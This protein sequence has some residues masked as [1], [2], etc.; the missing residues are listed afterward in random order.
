M[1]LDPT[2]FETVVPS[3]YIT[4]TFPNPLSNHCHL[5]VAVLDSP[6]SS[7]ARIASMWVPP[8]RES[9]WIFS[10]FSGH[11]QLLLSS[12]TPHHLSR[13]ILIGNPPVYSHP[14]S[15]SS[16]PYPSPN[17]SKEIE[18][19]LRPLLLG[20]TPK[21]AF[22]QKGICNSEFLQI[23][24]LIYEDEVVGCV[25]LEICE[26]PCAG[27]MLIENVAVET[28]TTKEFR[29]RLRFK[30]MPN[31]VQTQMRILPKNELDSGE[32]NNLE[33]E[34][35][36]N[37]LVH[38]YLSPMVGGLSVTE[39]HLERRIK[40]GFRPKALCLGIGGGA[41]L[42][43]LSSQLNFDVTGVEKD[44]VVLQIAKKYFGLESNE[45]IHL[46][47]GDGIEL[48][49]KLAKNITADCKF[50]VIMVDLDSSDVTLGVCAPPLEFVKKSVLQAAREVL[51]EHGVL[52]INVIPSSELFY[53]SLISEFE[54]VFEE[55][56]E[57]DVGNGENFVLIATV[58]K[59][60]NA[61]STCEDS[62]LNK[63]KSVSGSYIGSI[64]KISR[65]ANQ[66][67]ANSLLEAMR[68]QE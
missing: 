30:R 18:E 25:I 9:D 10:T 63:L 61:L 16:T 50:D 46:F 3:R 49:E 41:L 8:G 53:K 42:G 28:H 37:V 39:S 6:S 48:V 27:E 40:G 52:V 17:Q 14:T 34:I 65:S 15:Y 1:S 56:Y 12:T 29:R 20:L 5:R 32:L 58:S 38:P 60:E 54:D 51:C 35:D 47:V 21:S 68:L 19:R 7:A 33:F 62:L 55:L 11:L 59:I 4:F 64:R 67:S 44:E 22:Y 66:E 57:I 24:F 26:G 2:T 43:F 36:N 23:P 45:L 31:L 13:L